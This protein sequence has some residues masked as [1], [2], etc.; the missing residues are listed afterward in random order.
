MF[1][2]EDRGPKRRV[3]R[4]TRSCCDDQIEQEAKVLKC[5]RNDNLPVNSSRV[6]LDKKGISGVNKK[7]VSAHTDTQAQTL[8][9]DRLH[10]IKCSFVNEKASPF[11]I[12]NSKNTESSDNSI[13]FSRNSTRA[14]SV[15]VSNSNIVD[16]NKNYVA[17]P[18]L[19]QG[20]VGPGAAGDCGPAAKMASQYVSSKNGHLSV[21]SVHPL[22]TSTPAKS[23]SK[24]SQD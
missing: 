8:N 17:S 24:V 11:T 10:W 16:V 9:S 6:S 1:G 22:R 15:S 12:N 14:V 19:H 4:R 5:N 23:N 21:E 20:D 3:K 7:Q 2:E 13:Y 18:A